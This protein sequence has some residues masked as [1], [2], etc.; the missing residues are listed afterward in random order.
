MLLLTYRDSVW[1]TTNVKV[2]VSM[3]CTVL[4]GSQACFEG[5]CSWMYKR[6]NYAF[7]SK[8][9]LFLDKLEPIRNQCDVFDIKLK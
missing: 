5:I 7:S 9:N 2:K 6:P 4:R 8:C 3:W 1:L